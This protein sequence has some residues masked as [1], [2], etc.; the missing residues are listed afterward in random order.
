MSPLSIAVLAF[1]MT[2]D[3]YLAAMGWGAGRNRLSVSDV[4]RTGLLFA[5]VQ[6]ATPLI[7]WACGYAASSYVEPIDHW[8]AFALLGFVG[9]RMALTA[10][11]GRNEPEEQAPVAS[12]GWALF[13]T[14]VGTSIDAMAV[15]VS[16]AFLDVYNMTITFAIGGATFLMAAGGMLLGRV[17]KCRLGCYAEVIAGLV[18][19]GLGCGIVLEH[20]NWL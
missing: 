4:V 16:L 20:M 6:M 18:L 14:A 3:T 2:V 15:G 19:I 7:G 11:L 9:G 13:L 17:L 8:I 12:G 1:S 10:Y 5:V